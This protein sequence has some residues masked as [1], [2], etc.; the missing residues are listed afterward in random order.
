MNPTLEGYIAFIRD[1]MGITTDQLPDN[2]M[3][4]PL[5]YN[6]ALQIVNFALAAP[7]CWPFSNITLDPNQP[8]IYTLCVYNLAG[9][10]L[11]NWTQDPIDAPIYK[12]DLKFFAYTRKTLNLT[13]LT[14]GVIQSTNDLTTGGSYVVPDFFK[15][16]TLADLAYLKTPYG[17]QYLMFAQDYGPTEWGIS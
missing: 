9:D 5:T 14:T 3:F 12:N 11:L 15:N 4:I 7:N 17:Q 16:L 8:S 10:R 6:V 2:S 13:G 1:N